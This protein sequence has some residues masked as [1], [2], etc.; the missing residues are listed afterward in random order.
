MKPAL[1]ALQSLLGAAALVASSLLGLAPGAEASAQVY[2][3]CARLSAGQVR[4]SAY[5]A[6][7]VTFATA[8]DRSSDAVAITGC[9]RSGAGYAQEWQDWGYVGQR[10]FAEG[11][12]WEDTWK[13]PSGSFSIT[14]ALGRRD[15]GTALRYH[16]VRPDSRWGGERGATYNQ[17]FEGAGG[18]SDE[19]LWFFMNQ[20]YY[21]QAAVIN[22]NRP[23]D[24]PTVQGASFAIFFHAG[25]VPSAGCVSTS[26]ATVTRLLQTDRPGDRI[27]MGAVDDVFTPYSSNPF[28][29][30]SAAYGSAGG[31]FGRLGA[32][33]SNEV[34][35]R[36]DGGAYQLFQNGAINWSP[37]TG[38]HV[39]QGGIRSAW[40]RNGFEDGPLGYPTSEETGG[41]PGGGV[42]QMYQGGAIVWGP[43][44]GAHATRG[45]IRSAY[46]AVGFERGPLGYAVSDEAGN[47]RDGG[48]YQLFQ[49]GA[50]YWSPGTGAHLSLGAIRSAW[51]STGY[52]AGPLGYPTSDEL[53]IS[54][55]VYQR[56]QGGA[57]YWS[58][59]TGAHAV[60]G[61]FTAAMAGGGFSAVGFPTAEKMA[62]L[63]RGGAY[64]SFQKGL[65]VASPATGVH[66]SSGALRAAWG[67][68]DYERGPLG[69]PISDPYAGAGGAVLQDYE[70]G[71]IV[72]TSGGAVTIEGPQ[73]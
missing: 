13:S 47:L 69:Y 66:V 39:S 37:R 6:N 15:P 12:T 40:A 52:E 14:E 70:H 61:P 41:L 1:R 16:T 3:P 5:G 68:T 48:A 58:P 46:A 10:G 34:V 38:A 59:A 51:G 65:L 25:R 57:V 33:T 72:I 24:M 21:E 62:G 29:A 31:T 11:G 28:G 45:A 7:R 32:P 17:Y 4:F 60:T 54:G 42:Y 36:R 55:G 56:Y 9:V 18:E 23:P 43:G 63:V 19:N 30:I 73:S 67:G 71:K 35:G 53:R 64:Q 50:I 44:A 8:T 27:I 2:N 26:L 22:Y 20:G 49:R